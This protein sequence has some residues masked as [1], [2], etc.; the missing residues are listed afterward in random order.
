M[1]HESLEDMASN[2]QQFRET[3]DAASLQTMERHSILA[4]DDDPDYQE[5][6]ARYFSA[7]P[8]HLL[9]AF[10][11]ESGLRLA[12]EHRP[13]LIL[14]DMA[15]P[16][17]TGYEVLRR[18]H[19]SPDTADIPVLI[20]SDLPAVQRGSLTGAAGHYPKPLSPA[21]LGPYIAPFLSE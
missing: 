6:L 20:I 4:I 5:L 2:T 16:D 7:E 9:Q 13:R 17:S 1:Q 10:S 18:L 19:E 8:M 15:L 12:R 21:G 3:T 11:G 14:L